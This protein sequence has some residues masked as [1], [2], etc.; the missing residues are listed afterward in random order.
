MGFFDF[1]KKASAPATPA[2]PTFPL[3]LAADARDA[4]VGSAKITKGI[5]SLDGTVSNNA[6]NV[7][8]TNTGR[9]YANG[10]TTFLVIDE[11]GI[12]A[13]YHNGILEL[14]LPKQAP[15]VPQARQITIG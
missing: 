8:S 10:K 11:S 14:T 7:G 3:T 12:T 9:L 15:V 6:Y 4:A 5:P 13:A 2:E 1:L